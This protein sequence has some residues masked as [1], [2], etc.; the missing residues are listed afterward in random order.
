MVLPVG[1]PGAARGTQRLL[2]IE[3][4]ARGYTETPLDRVRFVPLETGKR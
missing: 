2:L 4:G 1:E 3:R